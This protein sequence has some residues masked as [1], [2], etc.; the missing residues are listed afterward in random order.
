MHIHEP[1][2]DRQLREYS[3]LSLAFIGDAVLELT[4]R[5]RLVTGARRR[6]KD[7]HLETVGVVKAENQA[8]VVRQIIG[9]LSEDEQEIVRWGRNARST[10]PR[11]ADPAD[12]ALSNGFETLLGY[13]YLKG[14]EERLLY[15]IEQALRQAEGSIHDPDRPV[16]A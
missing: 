7:L 13:L 3:P 9:E 12:Y 10:P 16:Q 6:M 2:D 1:L 5:T 14:E 4:V 8:K 11:N 15:L